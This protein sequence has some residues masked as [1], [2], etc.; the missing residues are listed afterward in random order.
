V[1][2]FFFATRSW[3]NEWG[4]PTSCPYE[5]GGAGRGRGLVR[6]DREF[7]DPLPPEARHLDAV[8]PR[9]TSDRFVLEFRKPATPAPK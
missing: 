2:P 1:G 3:A 7:D 4:F 6:V 8:L 5:G 9:G